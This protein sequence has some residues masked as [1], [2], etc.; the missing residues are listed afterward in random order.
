VISSTSPAPS[1]RQRS[2]RR[3]AFPS[4]RCRAEGKAAHLHPRRHRLPRAAPGA[5]RTRARPPRG[6]VQPRPPPA[7]LDRRR[8][9]AHRRSQHRRPEV[10]RERRVGRVHR[11]PHDAADLGARRRARPGTADADQG[12]AR[13][14]DPRSSAPPWWESFSRCRPASATPFNRTST[15][16]QR[17]RLPWRRAGHGTRQASLPARIKPPTRTSTRA[18]AY[19]SANAPAATQP[20]AMSS[21]STSKSLPKSSAGSPP[22]RSTRPGRRFRTSIFTASVATRTRRGGAT[23]MSWSG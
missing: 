22:R 18:R 7:I 21:R 1:A 20:R 17:L 8:R 13:N 6:A 2:A 12:T 10:A 11:Q 16:V 14:E 19:R 5:L 15:T 9:R 4:A 23:T 3:P